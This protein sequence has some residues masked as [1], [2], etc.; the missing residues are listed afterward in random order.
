MGFSHEINHPAIGYPHG[1]GIHSIFPILKIRHP[2]QVIAAQGASDFS[3]LL[4]LVEPPII[5][6]RCH[7]T[8]ANASQTNASQTTLT[9]N[10]ELVGGGRPPLWKIWTSIGMI[11]NPNIWENKIHVPNHQPDSIIW[12]HLTFPCKKLIWWNKFRGWGRSPCHKPLGLHHK[13]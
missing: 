5:L 3:P 8:W 9:T 6:D 11:S 7:K 2:Q 12:I 10:P 13:E 1:Y 4:F